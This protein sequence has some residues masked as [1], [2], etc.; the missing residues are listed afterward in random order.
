MG[1]AVQR[2]RAVK[3]M[4][5]GQKEDVNMH[6]RVGKTSYLGANTFKARASCLLCS[7][8]IGDKS[9]CVG[10]K[11][12]IQHPCAPLEGREL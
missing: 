7:R 10:N 5:A 8:P 2:G 6:L 1:G 4:Q 3:K 9:E 12:A 11:T